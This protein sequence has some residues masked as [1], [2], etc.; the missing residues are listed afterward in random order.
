MKRATM[1]AEIAEIPLNRP[2]ASI[3]WDLILLQQD[4]SD[5]RSAKRNPGAKE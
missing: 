2:S 1:C 5:A 4:I 3:F